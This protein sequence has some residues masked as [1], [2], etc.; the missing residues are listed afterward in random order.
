MRD[1]CLPNFWFYG[2]H[3]CLRSPKVSEI[4]NFFNLLHALLCY[5]LPKMNTEKTAYSASANFPESI[6]SAEP[7]AILLASNMADMSKAN[8]MPSC[9]ISWIKTR[10][11]RLETQTFRLGTRLIRLV[12]RYSNFSNPL[13]YSSSYFHVFVEVKE[14]SPSSYP[15]E[16]ARPSQAVR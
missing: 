1:P 10:V 4:A 12:T 16:P 3:M 2:I 14:I 8:W 6:F 15:K 7:R 13:S 9:V 5:L 11:L